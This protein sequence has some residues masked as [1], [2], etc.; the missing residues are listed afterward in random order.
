MD[1][2]YDD[3]NDQRRPRPKRKEA[4]SLGSEIEAY[5]GKLKV[6]ATHQKKGF[7]AKGITST[8]KSTNLLVVW[9]RIAPERIIEHTDNVVYSTRSE[10]TEIL[11]Y[12]DSSVFATEMT[13]DKELY[14]VKLQ[15]ELEKEI[16]D[17]KFL[18]S[19]KTRR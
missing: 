13:M 19:R 5:L 4:V 14:R 9:Q 12:M 10:N 2:D 15:N 3:K 7:Q 8:K 6:A 16:A 18:V 11:V 17:I 1:Y